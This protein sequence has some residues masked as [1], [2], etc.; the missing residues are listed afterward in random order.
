MTTERCGGRLHFRPT[1]DGNCR[2]KTGCAQHAEFL[3]H[4][5]HIGVRVVMNLL[6]ENGLCP[7]RKPVEPTHGARPASATAGDVSQRDKPLPKRIWAVPANVVRREI[8]MLFVAAVVLAPQPV[9]ALSAE[10]PEVLPEFLDGAAMEG[11]LSRET[12]VQRMAFVPLEGLR[13][14]RGAELGRCLGSTIRFAVEHREEGGHCGSKEPDKDADQDAHQL[15]L[16]A[17]D[18][19]AW[20]FIGVFIGKVVDRYFRVR[21]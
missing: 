15:L 8:R 9:Q 18:H 6:D 21:R 13:V 3:K 14:E 1:K 12:S 7:K 17:L 20:L 11:E 16:D 19:L 2:F 10:R 4:E 5:H